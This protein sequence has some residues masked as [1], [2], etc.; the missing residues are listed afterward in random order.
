VTRAFATESFA[1]TAPRPNFSARSIPWWTSPSATR[2]SDLLSTV[3]EGS[4]ALFSRNSSSYGQTAKLIGNMVIQDLKAACGAIERG[5]E[6]RWPAIVAVDEF[7]GLDGDQV[8]RLFQRARSA[9]Q[10][11]RRCGC[12]RSRPTTSP[13][14]DGRRSRASRGRAPS[15][16][17]VSTSSPAT[18]SRDSRL[19]VAELFA[20]IGFQG[21]IAEVEPDQLPTLETVCQVTWDAPASAG[22]CAR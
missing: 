7:S 13:C 21:Y 8:S 17:D 12:T 4:V 3:Q 1:Q 20:N 9:A 14:G 19:W 10:A 22:R 5:G 2:K 11:P 16:A 15:T 6:A 18:R